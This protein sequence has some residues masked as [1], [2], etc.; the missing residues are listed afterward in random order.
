MSQGPFSVNGVGW[1][2]YGQRDFGLDGSF[3][4]T[5]WFVIFHFPIFPLRSYRA[6]RHGRESVVGPFYEREHYS[7]SKPTKPNFKQVISTYVYS[8]TLAGL[9]AYFIVDFRDLSQRFNTGLVI[10]GIV[11]SGF[12]F[13]ILPGFLR[14][15]A[16]R[17]AGL[18][19]VHRS[20]SRR[21]TR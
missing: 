2:Y 5:E 11:I 15:R 3:I 16:I 4:M 12:I 9:T 20:R 10:G 7:L 18:K 19:V 13:L 17:K 21:Q 6:I 8:L 14:S 1:K